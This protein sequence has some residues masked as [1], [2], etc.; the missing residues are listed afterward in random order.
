MYM[1]KTDQ[2]VPETF[3]KNQLCSS[4]SNFGVSE[5]TAQTICAL[6]K[7]GNCLFCSWVLHQCGWEIDPNRLIMKIKEL[8]SRCEKHFHLNPSI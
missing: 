3:D 8:I 1:A 7:N 5:Y 6:F 2:V 4:V